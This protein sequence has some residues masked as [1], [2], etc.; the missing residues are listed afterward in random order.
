VSSLLLI[1]DDPEPVAV[2]NAGGLSPILLLGDHAGRALPSGLG[3]LGLSVA[4]LDRHIA[5]DIGVAGL[6]RVLARLL[7]ATFIHQHYSRL[8]IDCNRA[9]GAD[10][11][12]AEQSDG[13]R[14]PGN[15]D[16]TL[17]ARRQRIS[18]VFKPYH[19]RIDAEL[20]VRSAPGRRVIVVSLHSFTP[21]F[22]KAHRPWGFGV[23]HGG[24]SPFSRAVLAGLRAQCGEAVGD[25][26]P[27]A[28]N[29]VDFSI[30]F[31]AQRRGF[32]Y[33]E[34]EVRQNMIGGRSGQIQIGRLL[35]DV[36]RQALTSC[37]LA[38]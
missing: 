28:L 35:A 10:G 21:V 19:D 22:D 20:D 26:E 17:A 34:L 2:Y 3:D 33:L 29:E 25:N 12:M 6:G 30:P 16:L 11:S 32:D 27:Y 8:V 37:P 14:I 15:L 31:H 9:P 18:E 1:G 38:P 4:D 36:M 13:S 24:D 5:C 7:D 23:L